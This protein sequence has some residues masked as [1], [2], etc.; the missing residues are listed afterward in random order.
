MCR[1]QV[2]TNYEYNYH[3]ERMQYAM[4]SMK[5]HFKHST[6]ANRELKDDEVYQRT[7]LVDFMPRWAVLT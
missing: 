5:T 7:L 3:Q 4:Q 1:N 2:I 6:V